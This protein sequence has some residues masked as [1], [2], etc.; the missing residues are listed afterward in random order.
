[1]CAF[2]RVGHYDYFRITAGPQSLAQRYAGVAHS[3]QRI[4]RALSGY[5]NTA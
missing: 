1:M 4:T 2:D 3:P 5:R